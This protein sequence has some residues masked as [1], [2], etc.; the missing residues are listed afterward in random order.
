MAERLAAE[1]LA[2]IVQANPK[3]TE[4][5]ADDLAWELRFAFDS[6]QEIPLL[7]GITMSL[8]EARTVDGA[9]DAEMICEIVKR[10]LIISQDIRE[11][12]RRAYYFHHAA[13]LLL[14]IADH[15]GASASAP[16]PGLCRVSRG[17]LRPIVDA[18]PRITR[19][20]APG[21]AHDL[22][23]ALVQAIQADR[24][25]PE[26]GGKWYDPRKWFRSN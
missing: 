9:P 8:T 24:P 1:W 3:V 5:F 16:E 6:I 26:K 20:N 22:C 2:R 4:S 19:S 10:I 7:D 11:V 12:P 23:L 13:R 21:L 15:R 14:W 25:G 17:L 18:H